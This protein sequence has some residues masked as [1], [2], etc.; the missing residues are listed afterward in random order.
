[1]KATA[2]IS[3]AVVGDYVPP[4]LG[5]GPGH[6]WPRCAVTVDSYGFACLSCSQPLANRFQ[7]DAHFETSKA[8][9][10]HVIVELCAAHGWETL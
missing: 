10:T 2:A 3:P 9:Q 4:M 1:M 6:V 7:L 5:C 8:N